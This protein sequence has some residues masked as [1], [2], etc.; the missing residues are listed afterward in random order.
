MKT[1]IQMYF[2]GEI[3]D[4]NISHWLEE[5]ACM[6]NGGDGSVEMWQHLGFSSLPDYLK[7]MDDSSYLKKLKNE[8]N[9]PQLAKS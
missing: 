5:E 1:I 2:A 7:W 3:D 8:N 4:K 9:K 6:W